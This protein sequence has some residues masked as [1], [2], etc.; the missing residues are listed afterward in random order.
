MKNR[1][2]IAFGGVVAVLA[3]VWTFA[4]VSFG[5]SYCR[6]FPG[7]VYEIYE[8]TDEALGGSSTASLEIGDSL[9]DVEVNI[10]SGVAY[11]AVG[12]GFNLMSVDNRPVGNFD[13]SRFDSLEIEVAT[14][15]MSKVSVR[16]LTEDPTYSKERE[17][18]SMRP[19]VASVPAGRS[20]A[21]VKLP[22]SAFK[23]AVWWLA[24]VGLDKDDGLTYLQRG[25]FL[26]ITNGDGTMRGIPDEIS[27]KSISLW[28][29][30]RDF[31][32]GMIICGIAT[33]LLLLLV[34]VHA[35][36]NPAIT[37]EMK[38]RMDKAAKLLKSTD[39]S[40]AEIAIAVG[41][42]SEAAFVRDFCRIYKVKPLEYRRK[43]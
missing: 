10:R 13:F 28:G 2:W 39:R 40:V 33:V 25:S 11:P 9:L 19:L 42:K 1:L 35:V 26:E 43:K 38:S 16:I 4:F 12:F 15:R 27:V 30:N 37:A 20:F 31:K 8:L 21:Q 22:L 14:K 17:R 23:T 7:D 32:R 29:E 5:K 18:N 24:S 41:E 34:A 3:A 36:R 6:I